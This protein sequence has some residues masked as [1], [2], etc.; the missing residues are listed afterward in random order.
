[1]APCPNC[2]AL[3]CRRA[4]GPSCAGLLARYLVYA[5]DPASSVVA[6]SSGRLDPSKHLTV[7]IDYRFA[8]L[9]TVIQARTHLFKGSIAR[10]ILGR[11]VKLTVMI[12]VSTNILIYIRFLISSTSRLLWCFRRNCLQRERVSAPATRPSAASRLFGVNGFS[13]TSTPSGR[14]RIASVSA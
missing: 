1:V 11:H 8:R 14:S 4:G 9:K 5:V 3:G 13:S 2:L 6:L 7:I 10:G 12:D